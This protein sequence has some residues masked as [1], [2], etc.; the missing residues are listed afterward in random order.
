M[1]LGFVSLIELLYSHGGGS[2]DGTVSLFGLQVDPG[3][4]TVWIVASLVFG[5][6][7]GLFRWAWKFVRDAWEDMTPKLQDK[8]VV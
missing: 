5:I 7:A 3:Q 4:A 2:S 1:L 6:G 8:G